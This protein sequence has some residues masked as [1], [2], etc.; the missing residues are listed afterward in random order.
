ME[1]SPTRGLHREKPQN[2]RPRLDLPR[3]LIKVEFHQ[4]NGRERFFNRTV[5]DEA[6]PM[7]SVPVSR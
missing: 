7:K 2:A 1:R 3:V 6:S 5:M 4:W